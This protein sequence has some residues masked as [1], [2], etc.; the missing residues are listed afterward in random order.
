MFLLTFG[1]V[2]QEYHQV[3]RSNTRHLS[4]IVTFVWIAGNTFISM[5]LVGNL[6][7]SLVKSYHEERT[8]T[9]NEMVDKD[10]PI[11]ITTTMED[12][13]E[14]GF[15]VSELNSRLLCQARK[16]DLIFTINQ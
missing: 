2:F 3:R 14:A 5:A 1:I 12:Y 16:T 7:S 10:M 9:L 11:H 6:K 4:T 13:L 8:K 15:A